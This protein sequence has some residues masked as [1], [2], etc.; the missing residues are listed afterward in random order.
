MIAPGRLLPI[1][2]MGRCRGR[3][4]SRRCGGAGS[5]RQSRVAG[6][7]VR[8]VA[9]TSWGSRLQANRKAY[10]YLGASSLSHFDLACNLINSPI[11]SLPLAWP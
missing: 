2:G 10:P 11:P 6:Q 4:T 3:R 7:A 5:N 9:L 1:D 8:P